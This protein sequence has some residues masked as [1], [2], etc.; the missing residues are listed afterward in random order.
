M[1]FDDNN[2]IFFFQNFKNIKFT[3]KVS[4]IC[5]YI[6]FKVSYFFFTKVETT[7]K[8]FRPRLKQL[9]HSRCKIYVFKFLEKNRKSELM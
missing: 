8:C 7:D 6:S 9:M 2:N 3:S 5:F 4:F 1:K